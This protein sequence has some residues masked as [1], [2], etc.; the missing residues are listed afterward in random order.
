MEYCPD[1]MHP[2]T[3]DR[4]GQR[5]IKV[6][7]QSPLLKRQRGPIKKSNGAPPKRGRKG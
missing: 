2:P 3:A 6:T 7:T 4:V 5:S 1:T